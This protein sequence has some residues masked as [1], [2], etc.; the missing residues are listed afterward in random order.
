M[1]RTIS[2]D[3]RLCMSLSG[4][5]GNFGT[6]FHNYLYEAL[7]LDF[8]YKAFT[9]T[10]LPAAIGGIRALGIRG[11]AVSMPF[12]EACI[13]LLDELDPSALAIDSV[14]TI[15]ADNGWLKGYNTDYSAVASLLA[16]HAVPSDI[17]F[18]VRGSGGMAKAVAS[19]LR[20]S[21]FRH[22]TIV[23][24]NPE[25]GPALSEGCGYAWLAEL[26]D[27]HP[28]MLVNVT[29]IG[30]QGG[31]EADSL[32]FTREQ[33]EAAEWV[34]DVVALPVETPL[35]RLARELGKPVITGAEVIV[36]QAVEQFVLYTGVRPEAGLIEQA[37]EFA[38]G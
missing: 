34:F 16:S 35:I 11:C 12:K 17:R 25:A 10:D 28:Q 4:R 22:G 30:M 33:V 6:R 8:V 32:A 5:P 29:P 13:P 3:T 37:A 18:A 38:R 1:P 2:R 9:T 14:N 19:A 31:P 21:G 7:D 20:D 15:V 23:A 36:L 24:R 27:E 26:G